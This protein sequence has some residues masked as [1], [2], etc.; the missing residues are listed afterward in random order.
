MS[1]IISRRNET[2]LMVDSRRKIL[3]FIDKIIM[4]EGV[5]NYT[6]FHLKGGKKRL[7]AHTLHT[8]EDDLSQ[9][10]FLRVHRGFIINSACVH[11]FNIEGRTLILENNLEATVSRRRGRGLAI[12]ILLNAK[13][14]TI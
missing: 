12:K 14:K 10:G 13:A 4:L 7:F 2:L 6:I 5:V 3:L 9:F 11:D 1:N 8:Y